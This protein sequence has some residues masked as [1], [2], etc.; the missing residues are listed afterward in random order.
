MNTAWRCYL[1]GLFM[2]VDLFVRAMFLLALAGAGL[3]LIVLRGGL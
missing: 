2:A 3:F 1:Y